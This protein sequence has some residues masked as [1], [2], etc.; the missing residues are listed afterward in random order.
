MIIVNNTILYAL[1][2][3]LKYFHHKKEII[4]LHD[5]GVINAKVVIIL[6]CVSL[7]N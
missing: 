1:K 3:D 6:Q 7:S 2:L 4:M 5:E